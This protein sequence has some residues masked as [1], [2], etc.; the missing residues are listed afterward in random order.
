MPI[1]LAENRRV[2][3]NN[4]NQNIYFDDIKADLIT[5]GGSII[6]AVTII[7][8]LVLTL[9]FIVPS[10]AGVQL[11][12]V[13]VLTFACW[14]YLLNAATERLLVNDE[15][16]EY[17]SLL[18]H[19]RRFN[20]TEVQAYKLTNL[21]IRLNG[22]FYIFELTIVKKTKPVEIGLGPCW[23][24]NQLIGFCNAIDMKLR[25]DVE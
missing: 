15:I 4:D 18:T 14:M 17:K 13:A 16:I 1:I 3:T 11:A 20:L 5:P 21:G 8:S 24:Q 9:S 19:G 25:K 12:I 10:I 23:H 22:D 7:M 6:L 2:I